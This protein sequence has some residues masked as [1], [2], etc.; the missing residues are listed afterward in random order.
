MRKRFKTALF[1]YSKRDVCEYL[2][3]TSD[4]ISQKHAG[5]IERIQKEFEDQK[6][7]RENLVDKYKLLEQE[8]ESLK[9]E[10]ELLRRENERLSVEAGKLSGIFV[11]AKTFADDLKSKAIAQNKLEMEENSARNLAEAQRIQRFSERIDRMRDSIRSFLE[12]ADDDLEA[13]KAKLNNLPAESEEE[14]SGNILKLYGDD[15]R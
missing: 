1:G 8:L 12:Q 6:Q 14:K 2:S 5:D 3:Q 4:Q 11:D 15:N 10:N 9:K 13:M 7:E